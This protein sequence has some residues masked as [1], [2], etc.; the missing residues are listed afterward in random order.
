MGASKL[1]AAAFSL[2]WTSI[3]SREKQKYSLSLHATES[4][5]KCQPDG[6]LG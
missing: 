2:L 6:P 3:P 1:N 4:E 5:D